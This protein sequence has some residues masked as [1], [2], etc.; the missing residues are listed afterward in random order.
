MDLKYNN[1]QS[2]VD[3]LGQAQKVKVQYRR[4]KTMPDHDYEKNIKIRNKT[5]KFT[6]MF[7]NLKLISE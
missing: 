1:N 4:V 7:K 3:C 5:K 6:R 2:N